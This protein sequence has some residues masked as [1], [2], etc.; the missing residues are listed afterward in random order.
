[1]DADALA[2]H[3][4][5]YIALINARTLS[6]ADL[7]PFAH[8]AVVHNDRR[9]S[10]HEYGALILR[11]LVDPANTF[12]IAKL[13]V[14]GDS[15]AVRIVFDRRAPDATVT[16]GFPYEGKVA[17]LEHAFYHFKEGRISEV[18]S[19]VESV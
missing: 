18:W 6:A 14:Q 7:A 9:L 1:M 3:Y 10:R 8:D 17:M 11:A 15:V 5:A 4:R 2:D 12:N 19:L 13:V 16:P